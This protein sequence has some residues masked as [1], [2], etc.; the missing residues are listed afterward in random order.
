[1]TTKPLIS[2]VI[3][4]FN[5]CDTLKIT[6]EKF[7]AVNT[8]VD[9]FEVIVVDDGSNDGTMEMVEYLT[10][11][12]PYILRSFHHENRGPGF[13]QNRGIK[14]AKCN[15]V[16]LIADDIWPTEQFI[17]QHLKTHYEYPDENIAVLGKVVQSQELPPTVMNKYWNPF[18]YDRFEGKKQLDGINFLACNISLKK[19]FL[20]KNGMYKERPGV[21]HEDIELG[22][23]LREKGLSIIYNKD[24]LAYHYHG[25]NLAKACKRGYERGYNFDM[26]SENIPKSFIFPI[27]HICSIEAGCKVFLQMLPREIPRLLLFN[28]GTVCFF[29]RPILELAEKNSLAAIFAKSFSYRGVV[30][31]YQRK[32]YKDMLKKQKGYS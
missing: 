25:D 32:G 2:I 21:A 1:M 30:G 4:T 22:Y 14:E 7:A 19:S 3:A 15:L 5:R 6:L 29:W 10:T 12:L 17:D 23:R 8:Q 20:A 18:R 11:S 28:G 16:V 13:T 9:S 27:Y 26:I 24:A 31:Y